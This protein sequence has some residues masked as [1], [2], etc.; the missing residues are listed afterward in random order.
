MVAPSAA[1]MPPMN[2]I[3]ALWAAAYGS[4]T[5]RLR[6]FLARRTV[7]LAAFSAPSP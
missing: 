7:H 5:P 2:R 6:R 1:T 4:H 3:L